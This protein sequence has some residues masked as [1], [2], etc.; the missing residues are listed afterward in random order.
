M[1]YS[2]KLG[3]SLTWTV[4]GI[5]SKPQNKTTASAPWKDVLGKYQ[6]MTSV[7]YEHD[8]TSASLNL[9][10]MG[11]RVNNSKQTDVKPMLL[12]NL[13]IGHEVLPNAVL[14]LDINNIFNR[15]DLT[16]PTA[17]TIRRAAPS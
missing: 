10:Y 3:D 4:G 8:K 16:D 14:T 7:D 6:V 9:S 11:G 15:R 5:Y 13:H 2:K 12:S 17:Y 1:S